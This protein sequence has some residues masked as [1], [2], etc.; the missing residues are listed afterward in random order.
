MFI[1]LIINYLFP[2]KLE[3]KFEATKH[4]IPDFGFL[5]L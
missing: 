4:K 1:L 3:L 2:A 5:A